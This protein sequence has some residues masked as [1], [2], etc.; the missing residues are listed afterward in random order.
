MLAI[1]VDWE[2]NRHLHIHVTVE[3]QGLVHAEHLHELLFV[4]FIL[5]HSPIRRAASLSD[6]HIFIDSD[7]LCCLT[8]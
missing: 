5:Y 6:H 2:L 1:G 3:S 8:A 7:P 4:D